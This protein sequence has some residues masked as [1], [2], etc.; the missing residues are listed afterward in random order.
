MFKVSYEGDDVIVK[1]EYQGLP[2]VCEHYLVFGHDTTKSVNTQVAKLISLQKE[3]ED[4]LDPGWSAIKAKGKRKVGESTSTQEDS[5]AEQEDESA[6]PSGE[7]LVPNI[8]GLEEMNK[9]LVEI[10]QLALPNDEALLKVVEKLGEST[11]GKHISKDRKEQSHQAIA[12]KSK[13]SCK[14]DTSERKK[15]KHVIRKIFFES[16]LRMS[17]SQSKNPVVFLGDFNAMRASG[18]YIAT[19][20]DRVLVNE[21]WLDVFPAS[22]ATFF[23]SNI[24]DHS[25]AM[26]TVFDEVVSSK[27]PFKFFDFWAKHHDFLPVISQV[28]N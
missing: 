26:V 5:R 25:P 12:A 20:I 18:D 16:M 8:A 19:K 1:V 14:G 6:C 27:K 4:E 21:A 2:A 24:S 9:K 22:T 10:A 28:W 7:I 13:S 15:K 11:P 3:I 17:Q 23:P